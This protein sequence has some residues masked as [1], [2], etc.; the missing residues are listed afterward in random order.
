MRPV[1]G[2]H[3]G[4][5][6]RTSGHYVAATAAPRDAVSIDGQVRWYA[7][8]ETA[9]RGFCPICGANLF[10]DG[11]GTHLSIF[12]GTLDQPTG[13]RMAGHIFMADKGDYYDIADGLPQAL[14]E[15]ANLTTVVQ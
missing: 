11:P 9:R 2:C 14:Q 3:C 1:T 10:W 4:Q 12:A 8:S 6:R 13:L 7:S 5:C 15:D